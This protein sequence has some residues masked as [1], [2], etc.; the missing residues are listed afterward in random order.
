[1][2]VFKK[3][4][5]LGLVLG[6]T[7]SLVGCSGGGEKTKLEQIKDNG[8]LVVGTSAEFPPFEFHKVVDGKDSIKG[9]DI[10]LAEEFAKELGVKVEIKDMSF[11]GLIGALNADQV[12]IVL[13]GMSSTPEREKSVDFSELYY[14]SRNAVIVKDADIDKVK[15]E[16]DLKKLR[17]G[18]QAG[19]IQE[20]YVV[21]TLK[22]TT[23][24]SLKAIPDLITELKNGNIDAV[25]TN[26]AVS[27]INVKKYDGIKMANTEVGKDVT[28]GM[29]AAIKKSDNNK[30]FIELLNKKIKEL[31]DGKKIEEFLNEASTEAASN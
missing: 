26:E 14:L 4:L 18:V 23:T 17:V 13:A 6:L 8:K 24:K 1:M 21:N 30:D 31:Q 29:A 3:L 7:L 22:M 15:T 27:L 11:D 25:V 2:K 19:S 9:F 28:E 20:E 12:D 16:D 5:S 10:M